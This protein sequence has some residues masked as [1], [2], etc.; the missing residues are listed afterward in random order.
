MAFVLVSFLKLYNQDG[1]DSIGLDD[2][3]NRLG[4]ERRRIYDIV[5]ILESIGVL[6]RKA[7]NQYFW[8]GFGGI[9]SALDNLKDE[10]LKENLSTSTCCDSDYNVSLDNLYEGLPNSKADRKDKPLVSCKDDSRKEK[11]LALLSQNFIK[12][13]ISSKVDMMTLDYVAKALLGDIHDPTAMRNNSAAK[14]RRLYD[15]ANVFSSI[16]LI[17]KT[18]HPKS[19]KPA[20][21]WLGLE[22]SPKDG[23]GNALEFNEPKKR[24]FGTEI[25][26]SLPKKYKTES[27]LDW[28]SNEKAD[29][30]AHIRCNNLTDKHDR[31]SLEQPLKHSS[32]GFVFGPFSPAS[33]AELGHSENKNVRRIQDLEDL[34]SSHG[35]QYRNQAVGDLFG[36]YL[37][38]WKS[39]YVEAAKTETHSR[40]ILNS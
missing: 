10:A 22:G 29:T 11:S 36:H 13:F 1:V 12:L 16:N 20:F 6:S 18:H 37:A 33:V 26:N 15:I 27:S 8:K 17:E 34:A 7:K 32:N 23:P 40:S 31:N 4:I 24:V 35:P 21:R 2:A 19:R 14:V 30:P 38:A 3:A 28:N 25:T 9:P 5:N 39:W